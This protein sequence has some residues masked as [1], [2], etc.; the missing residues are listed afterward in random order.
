M[1]SH[2]HPPSKGP[3]HLSQ[4][5]R[6]EKVRGGERELGGQCA[7]GRRGR[8]RRAGREELLGVCL[9]LGFPYVTVQLVCRMGI[10]VSIFPQVTVH[11]AELGLKSRVDLLQVR[12]R[13]VVNM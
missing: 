4:E 6:D 12:P 8:R 9:P 2:G 3:G 5:G 1:A 11:V 7:D 10:G 13:K